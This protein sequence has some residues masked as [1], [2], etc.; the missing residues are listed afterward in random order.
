MS[1]KNKN[2]GRDPVAQ[3]ND[4]PISR[5]L[6][7]FN[8]MKEIDYIRN[9][10]IPVLESEGYEKIDLHHGATEIG[11]DLIFSRNKGFGKK[12]LSVAVV[13]TG[14]I[15]K[16]SSANNGL[17]VIMVQVDQAKKMKSLVG[18]AQSAFRMRY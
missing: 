15:S 5:L 10:V 13:K 14:K 1:I 7:K 8:E 12:S 2:K 17:P 16:S 3:M 6:T 9:I 11:K 18:T 4:S